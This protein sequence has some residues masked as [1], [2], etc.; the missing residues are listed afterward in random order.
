MR[1]EDSVSLSDSDVVLETPDFAVRFH[2]QLE[3]TRRNNGLEPVMQIPDNVAPEAQ[4]L[5]SVDVKNEVTNVELDL[6]L[7]ETKM[8]GQSVGLNKRYVGMLSG[9]PTIGEFCAI[10]TRSSAVEVL[11]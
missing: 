10:N 11:A 2:P 1:T 9:S 3:N 4:G 5:E 7:K 8:A 6:P